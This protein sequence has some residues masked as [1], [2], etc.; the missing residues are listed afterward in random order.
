MPTPSSAPPCDRRA[1]AATLRMQVDSPRGNEAPVI[2]PLLNRE[3]LLDGL[4]ALIPHLDEA[5]EGDDRRGGAPHPADDIETEEF[6]VAAKESRAVLQSYEAEVEAEVAAEG[7]RGGTIP[8]DDFVFVP[9]DA[10]LSILQS[11]FE[12]YLDERAPDAIDETEPPDDRR[13]PGDEVMI[14]DRTIV[15]LDPELSDD[16]RW[17]GRFETA[18]P[19]IFSDPL[20][21]GSGVAMGLRL[22]RGRHEFNV[23][24]AEHPIHAEAR[25]VVVGDW[26]SGIPRA[27]KVRDQMTRFIEEGRRDRR[28]VH[29]IHLGDVYYSGFG[30]EYEKRFLTPWPVSDSADAHSWTLAGNHDM[31]AGGHGYYKTC[32]NDPRFSGHGHSS[33]FSLTNGDWQFVGLDTAH[34][35]GG[36]RPPQGQWL[37]KQ[38]ITNPGRK[39]FLLSHHQPFSVYGHGYDELAVETSAVRETG[40][41]KA[42]FWG[43]EHGCVLYK[44]YMGIE[45]GRCVGN[46]GI[47][48]Y[49]PREPSDPY[50]EPA[51]WELRERRPKLGQPWNT[52]GF[53][54]IDLKGEMLD[55]RYVDEDGAIVKR[56]PI[57]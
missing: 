39:L 7:G 24:P 5:A 42:W 27:L 25:I 9:R 29:V 21:I 50:P 51:M 31:Y 4:R 41:V 30:W 38:A 48:E 52:F 23:R 22:A 16:R 18:K 6:A 34:K 3:F 54:V 37:A 46:G 13:G 43:H 19:K 47:P 10:L 28:E 53:A 57:A 55:V 17:F 35:G 2:A 14:T 20:W 26:G 45:F 15:G 36:L 56:E 11:T 1:L 33:W 8:L 32:L 44:P 49:M 40:R 12:Q